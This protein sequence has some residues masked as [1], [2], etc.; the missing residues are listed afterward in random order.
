MYL[1]F[2][3]LTLLLNK[4]MKIAVP[5]GS[6]NY[7]KYKETIPSLTLTPPFSTEA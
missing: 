5:K 4:G 7:K 3:W 1:L 6:D 2:K